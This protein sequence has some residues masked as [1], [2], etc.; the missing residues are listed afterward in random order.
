V[1]H[2]V[3]WTPRPRGFAGRAFSCSFL[4]CLALFGRL[5]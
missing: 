3:A 2:A 5:V 4:C 1:T